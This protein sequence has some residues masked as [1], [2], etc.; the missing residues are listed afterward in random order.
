MLSCA[1]RV[2]WGCKFMV[3]LREVS[4]VAGQAGFCVHGV[5]P[6]ECVRVIRLRDAQEWLG[7]M[8][9]VQLARDETCDCCVNCGV[10]GP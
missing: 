4:C 9:K 5:L 2:S 1:S 10:T 3:G 8:R 7:T 6:C